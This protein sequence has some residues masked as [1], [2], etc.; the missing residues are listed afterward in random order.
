MSAYTDFFI[1]LVFSPPAVGLIS[2][3]SFSCED[4]F[5]MNIVCI[6]IVGPK[7]PAMKWKT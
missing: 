6:R 4:Q 7:A 5:I 2:G 3:Q 1:I